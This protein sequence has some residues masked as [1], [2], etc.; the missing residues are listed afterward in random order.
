MLLLT[1][2]KVQTVINMLKHKA[3]MHLSDNKSSSNYTYTYIL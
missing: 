1:I 2:S 3:L